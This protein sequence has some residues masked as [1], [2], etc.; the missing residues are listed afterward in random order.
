M[1]LDNTPFISA[2]E[3]AARH[4]WTTEEVIEMIR[5]GSLVGSISNDQWFVDTVSSQTQGWQSEN[6]QNATSENV[7]VTSDASIDKV[8]RIIG[9]V[10]IGFGVIVGI[11]LLI[12]FNQSVSFLFVQSEAELTFSEVAIVLGIT[13]IYCTLGMLCL[14]IAK[15]IELLEK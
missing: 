15:V 4:G 1:Q 13:L 2:E 5:D 3:F 12:S 11:A 7:P 9:I 10:A 14:G 8:L 6:E